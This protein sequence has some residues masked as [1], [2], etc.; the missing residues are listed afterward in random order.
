MFT[1]VLVQGSGFDRTYEMKC[2]GSRPRPV[3]MKLA[4]I[5]HI[6]ESN[7]PGIDRML[8]AQALRGSSGHR[9]LDV[10]SGRMGFTSTGTPAQRPL[11]F[12][13]D[14][15]NLLLVSGTPFVQGS[16]DLDQMLRRACLNETRDAASILSSLEGAFAAL[17]WD[18][19][20]RR[21]TVVTDILG[22]QPIYIAA[23]DGAIL[24]ATELKGIAAGLG[25]VEMDPAGWGAFLSM[26]HTLGE[27]AMLASV[28]RVPAASIITWDAGSHTSEERRYWRWPENGCVAPP[29]TGALVAALT[30]EVAAIARHHVPG[31]VLLSGGFDSRLILCILRR[32]GLRPSALAVSHPGER[33]DADG[34]FASGIAAALNVPLE[35]RTPT[36]GFYGTRAYLDYLAMNEVA[37]PSLNLFIAS[38]SQFIRPELG[39]VWEGVAPGYTLAFPRIPKPTLECYVAHRC[40]PPTATIWRSAAMVFRRAHEMRNA[41]DQQLASDMAGCVPGDASL[42]EFEARHQMR[43]RMGHNP[44]K[45]YANDV[46]CFTPGV[47]REFWSLA[48][49][50]P[51]AAKWNFRLYFEIFRDH[52]P[53]GLQVPFCSMGQLWTDRF[54]SDPLYHWSKLFPPPGAAQAA[55]LLKRLGLR[56][57][58]PL[59]LNRVIACIDPE[60]PDL[61]RGEVLKLQRGADQNAVSAAARPLL[62][63][64]QV[65]RWLME[66]RFPEMRASLFPEPAAAEAA[67]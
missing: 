64:W 30:R 26:G 33:L 61:N 3:P 62:F 20:A 14:C 37:N 57:K 47:S 2:R 50:I 13:S 42:L 41:F 17:F 44:L 24:L 4:A 18:Q 7:S 66:G 53:E 54:R 67:Q 1:E 23:K 60:H 19:R 34:R 56:Q 5:L 10:L 21:L 58:V 49:R 35:F 63:Y 29:D 27:T 65:W 6:D 55:R 31:T 16:E 48:A 22:L 11:F 9:I 46:L 28:R 25:K 43:N 8:A 36:P 59:L 39:A 40:Q 51:Y 45:V 38:V 52:F 32:L 15:G 12:R